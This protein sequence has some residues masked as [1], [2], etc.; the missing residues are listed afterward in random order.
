MLTYAV[1]CC[2]MLMYADV[3]HHISAIRLRKAKAK[4]KAA[5]VEVEAEAAELAQ[6][7]SSRLSHTHF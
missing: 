4:A 1:L 7:T 6:C 5:E 3:V 2:L